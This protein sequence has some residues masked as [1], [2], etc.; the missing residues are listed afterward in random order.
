M[1]TN[2][3]KLFFCLNLVLAFLVLDTEPVKSQDCDNQSINQ[4]GQLAICVPQNHETNSEEIPYNPKFPKAKY[5]YAQAP[6]GCSGLTNPKRVRDTWGPVNFKPTCNEHDRCYYTL[7][8]N[9]ES[10]NE[11]FRI[12]LLKACKDGLTTKTETPLGTISIS[13]EKDPRFPAC[14]SIATSY[15]AAVQ[16]GVSF[17]VFKDAQKLQRE[18]EQYVA[19]IE[20]TIPADTIGRNNQIPIPVLMYLIN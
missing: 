5:P 11:Q 19:S 8:S 3:M 15:Y 18:Y 9:W 6:D 13:G 10:C 14:V 1:K 20:K 7:G 2:Q 17:N 16:A 12:G 4:P